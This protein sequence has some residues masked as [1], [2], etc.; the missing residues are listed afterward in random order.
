MLFALLYLAE[1]API[2]FLWWAMPTLLRQAGVEVDRIAALLVVVGLPWT[3]KMLGAPLV[4]VARGLGVSLRAVLLLAQA[5]M[6]ATLVFAARGAG[7]L[8]VGDLAGLQP[9][10]LAHAIAAAMQD[11]AID[12]LCI[13]VTPEPERGRVNGWMQFGYQLGRGAFGGGVLLWATAVG[14]AA[15]WWALVAVLSVVLVV[16]AAAV[17]RS[18]GAAPSARPLHELG[19][20]LVAVARQR[21]T[22][23]ALAFALVAAAGFEAVGALAGPF[24][25]DRGFDVETIARGYELPKVAAMVLGGLCGGWC[26]DRWGAGRATARL[27]VAFAALVLAVAGSDAAGLGGS[28]TILAALVGLYF[29]VGAFTT[30]SYALLMDLTAPR[31]AATQFSTY[32]GATNACETWAV[33]AAGGLVPRLGYAAAFAILA[34]AS[35][36]A[37]ALVPRDRGRD[38]GG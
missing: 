36:L 35:L 27:Q 13:S 6:I 8:Q 22:W 24:L 30:A 37:I 11:V 28:W 7:E 29:A 17:P 32:M 33:M 21:V 4:D 20:A 15:P 34:G 18:A 9:L 23:Q 31:L 5:V 12:A 16:A 3:L 38:G 2:G 1:G 26:A 19:A 10:L 14:P 25:I